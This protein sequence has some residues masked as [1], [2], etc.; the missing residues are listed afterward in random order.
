MRR[1][2]EC[3]EY[4]LGLFHKAP[5][6]FYVNPRIGWFSAFDRFNYRPELTVIGI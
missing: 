2:A 5:V 4:N 3:D 1:L 6:P